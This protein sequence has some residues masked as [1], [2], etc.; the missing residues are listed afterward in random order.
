MAADATAARIM[1]HPVNEI[2]QLTMGYDMGLGEIQEESIEII[3]EKLAN[4]QVDW[5]PAKL[6]NKLR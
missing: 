4:I 6:K 2:K 1:S 3:G 5:K